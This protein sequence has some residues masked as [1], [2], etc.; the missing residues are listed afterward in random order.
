M[1]YG[2]YMRDERNLK[3]KKKKKKSPAIRIMT[4]SENVD[5]ANSFNEEISRQV[6]FALA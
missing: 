4:K 5:L 6:E 2:V 1:G 3:K